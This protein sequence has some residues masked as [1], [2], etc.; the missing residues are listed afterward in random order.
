MA[1]KPQGERKMNK[2]QKKKHMKKAMKLSII[3]IEMADRYLARYRM[4]APRQ[5][6]IFDLE[7]ED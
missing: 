6:D 3:S 2:R 7:S 5:D 1:K 4:P